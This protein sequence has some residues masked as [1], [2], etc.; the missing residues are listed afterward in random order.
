MTRLPD[1][2]D[3]L[4]WWA[5]GGGLFFAAVGV[6][7]GLV[8]ALKKK[9]ADCPDGK[10]FPGDA[11]DLTCYVHPHAGLG[12]AVAVISVLLGILVVLAGIAVR[13]GLKTNLLLE[14]RGDTDQTP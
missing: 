5:T 7:D 6:V 1:R 12:I 10:I 8:L 3:N 4:L 14:A 11:T 13:A 2:T 9:E